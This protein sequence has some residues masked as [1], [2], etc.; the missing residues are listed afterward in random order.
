MPSEILV[1]TGPMKSGKSGKFIE[2][3][4]RYQREHKSVLVIKPAMDNRFGSKYKDSIVSRMTIGGRSKLVASI[5]AIPVRT[6]KQILELVAKTRCNV[7]AADE[8]QFFGK[9]DGKEFFEGDFVELSLHLCRERGINL[10][11]SGLDLTARLEPFGIMPQLLAHA[12]K[13]DKVLASC[14]ECGQPARYTQKIGGD[15]FKTVEVG[16]TNYEAR[17]YSCHRLPEDLNLGHQ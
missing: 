11:L 6:Y 3:V 14:Y 7:L 17:C 9:I 10:I 4:R 15:P 2:I 12:D 16:D 13:V 1:I 5:S 8:V